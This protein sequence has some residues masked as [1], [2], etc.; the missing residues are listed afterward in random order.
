MSSY[1]SV[2]LSGKILNNVFVNE[3]N[4]VNHSTVY[5]A[6]FYDTGTTESNLRGNTPVGEITDASY[7]RVALGATASFNIATSDTV[8]MFITN[9]VKITFSTAAAEYPNNVAFVALFDQLTGGNVLMYSS[10]GPKSVNIS[11]Y[12]EIDIDAFKVNM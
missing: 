5:A 10:V 7:A 12:V 2:Y 9:K 11:E 4:A 3:T 8:G 1:L 6:L